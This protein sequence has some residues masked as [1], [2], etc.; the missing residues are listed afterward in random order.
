MG[1]DGA[2]GNGRDLRHWRECAVERS[3]KCRVENRV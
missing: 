1:D 2:V 3:M